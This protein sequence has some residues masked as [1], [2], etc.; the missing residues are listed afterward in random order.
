MKKLKV[1]WGNWLKKIKKWEIVKMINYKD[2]IKQLNNEILQLE[3][4]KKGLIDENLI[5][6]AN[7]KQLEKAKNKIVNLEKI[8]DSADKSL[9]GKLEQIKELDDINNQL[10]TKTFNLELEIKSK[11]IQLEEYK[12]QIKDYQTEGRYLIKKVRTGRIPNT[13]KTKI[14]KPMSGNVVKYMRGEHE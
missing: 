2:E 13:N 4:D 9:K 5:Y 8:V 1:I 11:E 6:K 12:C 14:S 10:I 7:K 3:Q